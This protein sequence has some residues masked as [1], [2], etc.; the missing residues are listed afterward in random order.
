MS[1]VPST[2]PGTISCQWRRQ[3]LINSSCSGYSAIKTASASGQVRP[4]HSAEDARDILWTY[5]SPE[6][7]ELLVIERGWS[8][9]RYARFFADG[10]IGALL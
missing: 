4:E 3:S 1:Q 10:V 7:Y 6:V 5:H 9:E 2:S 8:V